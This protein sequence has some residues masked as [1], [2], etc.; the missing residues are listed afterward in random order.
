MKT[1][2]IFTI[3]AVAGLTAAHAQLGAWEELSTNTD[4]TVRD[5]FFVNSQLGFAVGEDSLFIRTTDGGDTWTQMAFP[6]TTEPLGNDGLLTSIWFTSA[7]AGMVTYGFVNFSAVATTNGGSNWSPSL[8]TFGSTCYPNRLFFAAPNEGYA[9]GRGCFGGQNIVFFDGMY[10]GNSQILY[11]G[12][13]GG[14]LHGISKNPSTGTRIA[15]GD[16]GKIFRS[17]TFPFTNVDTIPV[18]EHDT[19]RIMTVDYA[20]SNTF[21]AANRELFYQVLVSTDDGQSFEIDSTFP[22]TFWYPEAEELDFFQPDWGIMVGRSN[23]TSGVICHK[24]GQN[25][26]FQS[27]DFPLHAVFVVDSTLAFV[28]G[29]S[30]KIYRYKPLMGLGDPGSG[31][32]L[33]NAYPNPLGSGDE[34]HI[35][36]PEG[37][38]QAVIQ[39]YSLQG[40]KLDER[41]VPEGSTLFNYFVPALSPGIYLLHLHQKEAERVTRI[42]IR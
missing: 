39:L 13:T 9:V 32:A 41:Q 4:K 27:T 40:V 42:I 11:Y 35:A 23:L 10:W 37:G 6:D 29:D 30:G 8:G 16:E 17:T 26:D 21:Y 19:T 24:R 15:V 7:N 1:K 33:L 28:G 31:P 22:P 38:S 3:I 14:E 36:L 12:N 20:G 18:P 5:I 2:W 25:W 34:L